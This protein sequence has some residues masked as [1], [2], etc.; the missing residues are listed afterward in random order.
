MSRKRIIALILIS[1]AII[2]LFTSIFFEI[3]S[4][5]LREIKLEKEKNHNKAGVSI[6]ITRP[7]PIY[8]EVFKNEE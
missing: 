3:L 2:L 8:S 1:I 7:K 6:T 4:E 5:R